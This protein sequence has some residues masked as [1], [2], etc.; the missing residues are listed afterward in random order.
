VAEI[1]FHRLKVTTAH[2]RDVVSGKKKAEL[3]P[4]DGSYQKGDILVLQEWAGDKF[5]ERL[6][7]VQAT[8]ISSVQSLIKKDDEWAVI[9]FRILNVDSVLS[10]IAR[11]FGDK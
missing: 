4:N 6:I 1:R 9:S 2:Y 8:H 3:Q 5:T 10:L 7:V 11:V